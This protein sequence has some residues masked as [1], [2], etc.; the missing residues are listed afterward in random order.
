MASTTGSVCGPASPASACPSRSWTRQPRRLRPARLAPQPLRAGRACSRRRLALCSGRRRRAPSPPSCRSSRRRGTRSLP[1]C[2]SRR[3]CG[4]PSPR[5]PHSRQ[6]RQWRTP[7]TRSRRL[8]GTPSPRCLHSRRHP[9][10]RTLL[11]RQWAWRHRSPSGLL[12][13]STSS[14]RRSSPALPWLLQ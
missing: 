14:S 6:R 12:S 1:S 2:R 8:C 10:W 13:S 5:R 7:T 4:R 11:L 3:L 9:L